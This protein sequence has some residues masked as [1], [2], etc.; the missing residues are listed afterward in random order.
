MIY[1]NLGRIIR[2]QEMNLNVSKSNGIQ[3]NLKKKLVELETIK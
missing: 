2:D 1:L 3:N